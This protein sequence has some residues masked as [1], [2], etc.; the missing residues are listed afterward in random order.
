MLNSRPPYCFHQSCDFRPKQMTWRGSHFRLL[1]CSLCLSVQ[2]VCSCLHGYGA[3][4]VE[5][6]IQSCVDRDGV[7]S[8]PCVLSISVH[9]Y[10]LLAI[11]SMVPVLLTVPL[12]F[13]PVFMT[14]VSMTT[15]LNVTCL[16]NLLLSVCECVQMEMHYSCRQK[17]PLFP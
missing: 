3:C 4:S 10:L 2:R 11:F 14:V 8:P 7:F 9:F 12:L 1:R 17:A 13:L 6:D 15:C 16:C 5:L